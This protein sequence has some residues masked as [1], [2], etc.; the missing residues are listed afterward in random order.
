MRARYESVG[1]IDADLANAFGQAARAAFAVF[2]AE[3]PGWTYLAQLHSPATAA[4]QLWPA[5]RR[6]LSDNRPLVELAVREVTGFDRL[7][8]LDAARRTDLD[9]WC[10]FGSHGRQGSGSGAGTRDRCDA[11]S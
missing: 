2:I 3:V 6:S 8:A 7:A 9:Q 4:M 11:H 10:A 1:L 5:D